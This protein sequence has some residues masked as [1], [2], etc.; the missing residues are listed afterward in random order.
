[1]N[2]PSPE[3]QKKIAEV[4]SLRWE[5]SDHSFIHPHNN[6]YVESFYFKSPRMNRYSALFENTDLKQAE[7][8]SIALDFIHRQKTVLDERSAVDD[9]RDYFLQNPDES[10]ETT[11]LKFMLSS[12]TL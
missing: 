8:S 1:M 4:M 11:K 9:V 10:Y 5:F 12:D 3:M 7:A 2:T 6:D